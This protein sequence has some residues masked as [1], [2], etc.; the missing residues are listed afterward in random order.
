M[1][2]IAVAKHLD[3]LELVTYA[4][5]DAWES[6]PPP[7]FVGHMPAEPDT[8]V[9]ILASGGPP[10]AGRYGYDE[11]AV[12]LLVR[13]PRYDRRP[14][15]ALADS[16]YGALQNLHQVVLDDGGADEAHVVRCLAQQSHPVDLGRDENERH[17]LSINFVLRV[18]AL[19]THRV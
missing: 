16:L 15:K 12:Q 11:P 6:G 2:D 1:I 9:M 10:T 4:E 19:T 5:D 14:A 7:I 3:G 13:G 8:A 18:R 17:E